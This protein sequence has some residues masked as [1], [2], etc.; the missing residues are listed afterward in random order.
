MSILNTYLDQPTFSFLWSSAVTHTYLHN[1]LAVDRPHL[2][3][4]KSLKENGF[5]ERAI[6]FFMSD[7]GL[8][9]GKFRETLMGKIE[10]NLPYLYIVI[11][12]WFR[13][14]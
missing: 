11:P 5:L 9:F 13:K 3:Y 2:R 12:D 8:R 1:I 14:R 4:L 7:H 6:L 10:E